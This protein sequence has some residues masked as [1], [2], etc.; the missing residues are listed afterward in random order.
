MT[1]GDWVYVL[2]TAAEGKA[3]NY[4]YIGNSGLRLSVSSNQTAEG[5]LHGQPSTMLARIKSK[6]V[7]SGEWEW[8]MYG[9]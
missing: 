8:R 7:P 6:F 1:D 9:N 3:L 2:V 4:L 5:A